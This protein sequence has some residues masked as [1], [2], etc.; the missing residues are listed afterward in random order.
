MSTER[1]ESVGH[2]RMQTIGMQ[3]D[4]LNFFRGLSTPHVKG[5]KEREKPILPIPSCRFHSSRVFF[6]TCSYLSL[7]LPFLLLCPKERP[8]GKRERKKERETGEQNRGLDDGSILC[9]FLS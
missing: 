2:A 4:K 1:K 9:R 7:L 3:R 6:V 8:K 5:E